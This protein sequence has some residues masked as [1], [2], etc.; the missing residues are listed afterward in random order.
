MICEKARECKDSNTVTP[1]DLVY[2]KNR[3]YV[4]RDEQGTE[5][6]ALD[7]RL[8]Q[9]NPDFFAPVAEERTYRV[10]MR[11]QH[12]GYKWIL[13]RV[14]DRINGKSTVNLISPDGSGC[15][16]AIDVWEFSVIT[17]AEMQQIT[18]MEDFE[19]VFAVVEG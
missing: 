16:N 4:I 2:G 19:K 7:E 13:A 18:G 15:F 1:K 17:H 14:A 10:G 5:I 8:V 12:N 3:M 11:F 9:C 6:V